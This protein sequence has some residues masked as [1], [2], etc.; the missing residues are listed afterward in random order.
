MAE[1]ANFNYRTDD[2][3]QTLLTDARIATRAPT[4][5]TEQIQWLSANF[6]SVIGLDPGQSALLKKFMA[7]FDAPPIRESTEVW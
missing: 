2:Q 3:L 1:S 4:S 5:L 7:G 6:Q